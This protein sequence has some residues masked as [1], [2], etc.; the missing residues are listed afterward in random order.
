MNTSNNNKKS[1]NPFDKLIFEEGIR[2][3]KLMIDKELDLLLII[4]NNGKVLKLKLS[5]YSSLHNASTE[6]LN[7]WALTGGGVGVRWECLDV[8]LSI[9]GFIKQ[10]ALNNALRSLKTEGDDERFVA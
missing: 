6:D 1:K 8:D 10:A 2:A 3:S 9:K 4:L 7:K 5:D